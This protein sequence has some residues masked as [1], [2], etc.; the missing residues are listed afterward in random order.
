MAVSSSDGFR[1]RRTNAP[2]VS[3]RTDDVWALDADRCWAVNS[4]GNVLR[5]RDGGQSW[6]NKLTAPAGTYLRCVGFADDRSGWVGTLD[7]HHRMFHTADGG[8]TWSEVA[9]PAGAPS[10]VCGLCV[11]NA[12][13]TWAS[14]TNFP[15]EPSGVVRTLDGGR[16]W[17]AI[18]LSAHAALLVDVFF[19][20]ARRGWVVGGQAEVPD[21]TREDVRAVVLATEDGGATWVNQLAGAP[22]PLG[23]WGWKIQFVDRD[24]GFVALESF[25]RGAVLKTLDGGRSW[26]RHPVNDPQGN[27]N[28][29]GVGFIDRDH[30]WAGG[31]GDD[32]FVSGLTSET[33]DGGQTW[34]DANHVGRYLNRFR[35]VR[36]PELVGYASGD[37]VYRYAAE[38]AVADAEPP[39]AD[40]TPPADLEPALVARSARPVRIPLP[41]TDQPLRIDLWDRFGRR[42]ATPLDEP[43]REIACREVTWDGTTYAGV[44][45]AG[46]PVIYRISAGDATTSGALYVAPPVSAG[47]RA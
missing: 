14:G 9:L 8:D 36:S 13:V 21:P 46:G 40:A 45:F 20:D 34:S 38:P 16:T 32:L 6:E 30:G 35:F 7:S 2:T 42:L 1:W 23:E 41:V 17:T 43:V 26:S 31:W 3:W 33:R 37:T 27:V 39:D 10:A 15:E 28:L 24:V 44:E 12:D 11:V 5:T 19:A 47:R 4:N 18:D 25:S 22:M 29:E